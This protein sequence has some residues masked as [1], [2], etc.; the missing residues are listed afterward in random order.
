MTA[1]PPVQV[2]PGLVLLSGQAVTEVKDAVFIALHHRKR[3]NLPLNDL[4]RIA[5]AFRMADMSAAGRSNDVG[6]QEFPTVPLKVAARRLGVSERQMRRLA[7]GL[8]GQQIGRRWFIDE[9][10]LTEHIGG[11]NG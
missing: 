2:W 9:Q 10:A 7:P 1:P 11:R 3:R 6:L 5:T 4:E 8:S